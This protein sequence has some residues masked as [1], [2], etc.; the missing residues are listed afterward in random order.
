MTNKLRKNFLNVAVLNPYFV[1]G[2][3]DAEGCFAIGL[4]K[5]SKR[6]TG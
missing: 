1:T 3:S 5:D 6:K 2:F 4:T